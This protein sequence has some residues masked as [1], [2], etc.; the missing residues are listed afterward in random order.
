MVAARPTPTALRD[1]VVAVERNRKIRVG[2]SSSE[3]VLPGFVVGEG[4]RGGFGD[5]VGGE[6]G[7]WNWD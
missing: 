5:D 6:E 4:N 7:D 1:S 3:A 2:M